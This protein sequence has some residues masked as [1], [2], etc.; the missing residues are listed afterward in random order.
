MLVRSGK[1]AK[2]T[3]ADV[4]ILQSQYHL[5]DVFDFRFDLEMTE[6]PDRVISG[7][8]YTHL[9]TMPQMLIEAMKAFGAGSGQLSTP[10]MSEKLLKYAFDPT[11]QEL[12]K[13]LYPLIV[14][15]TAK[16]W[17]LREKAL[18]IP[19]AMAMCVDLDPAESGE[20]Y[21]LLYK[22]LGVEV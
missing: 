11:V 19:E 9:S 12:A 6:A 15:V 14:T 13:Q 1:L 3:D 17:E 2:A 10:G 8:T 4:A 22:V 7:V 21:R 20:L 18:K 16:G 5:S